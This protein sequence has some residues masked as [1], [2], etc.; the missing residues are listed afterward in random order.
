M[1]L[2]ADSFLIDG[3]AVVCRPNGLSDFNALRSSRRGHEVSLIASDLIEVH[4]DLQNEK[5]SDR[6]R[7][8]A[9]LLRH[10]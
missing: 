10:Q 3:E 9:R 1:R 5:L 4:G 6:K 8:L 2:R 7:H